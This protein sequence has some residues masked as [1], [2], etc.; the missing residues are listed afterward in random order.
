[1]FI[2]NVRVV[3][4][5]ALYTS[6]FIPPVS[7]LKNVTNTKLL[8]L[9]DP[10]NS[11]AAAVTPG[12]LTVT[13]VGSSGFNPFEDDIDAAL[14]VPA[15]YATLNTLTNGTSAA[16]SGGGYYKTTQSGA[17]HER[18]RSNYTMR[19]GQNQGKY[20]FEAKLVAEGGTYSHIGILNNSDANDN[21]WVGGNSYGANYAS[22]T[23]QSF[24]SGGNGAT[25]GRS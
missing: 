23:G 24:Y 4:G 6:N 13:Q 3:K 9:Q 7:P 11:S 8:C 15:N 5:T 18:C 10:L 25:C 12:T 21:N 14:G 2:S 17:Q 20:F 16:I 19:C 1:M 22:G